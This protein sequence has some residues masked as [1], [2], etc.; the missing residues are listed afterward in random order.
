MKPMYIVRL[1]S[2][3]IATSTSA[4][5][6][7][8]S[9]PTSS[10]STSSL[11]NITPGAN[12]FCVPDRSTF[13]FTS[14]L[15]QIKGSDA[16]NVYDEEVDD[17]EMEFSDDEDERAHKKMLENMC[18]PRFSIQYPKCLTNLLIPFAFAL[19]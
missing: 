12:V 6:T 18:V 5:G 3:S 2:S 8:T 1:P 11:N 15:R 17:K 16:S 10:P 19:L 4:D 7:T 9:L 14:A 13:L